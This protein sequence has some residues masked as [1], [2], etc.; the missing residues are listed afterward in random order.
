MFIND[1]KVFFDNGLLCIH[2][3]HALDQNYIMLHGVVDIC[4]KSLSN[5]LVKHLEIEG[6]V[7]WSIEAKIIDTLGGE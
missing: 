2:V 3:G 4:V 1:M 5:I 6:I 7:C